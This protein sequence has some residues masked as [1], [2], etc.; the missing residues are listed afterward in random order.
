MHLDR[1]VVQH[2]HLGTGCYIAAKAHGL[3]N[4]AE[5][6]LAVDV[7]G[8]C[9]PT[10]FF[11]RGVQHRQMLG[12]FGHQL[13]AQ[14]QRVLPGSGSNFID[15]RLQINGVLV[16]VDTA[17]E[18]GWNMRIAHGM[19]DQQIGKAVTNRR[20]RAA[21]VQTLEHHRIFAIDDVLR[22]HGGKNRLAGNA[23][24]QRGDIA[25]SVKASGHLAL[26]DGVV[27][28][29]QHVFLTRPDQLDGHARHFLGNGHGLAH[30]VGGAASAKTAPEV[31][32]VHIT[33]GGRQASGFG[34]SGQGGF[35]VLGGGPHF[36][37]LRR[38]ARCRVHGFHRGVVL[39]R[40]GIHRL[41][42]AGT[43]RNRCAGIAVFIADH[44][45]FVVET[46]F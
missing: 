19:V 13:A 36:T 22:R 42:F 16:Q 40:V 46:G 25:F 27:A 20:F 35:T 31:K 28:A 10:A 29:V 43:G 41:N 5:N 24:V 11:C 6:L 15:E 7:G 17:P 45:V 1:A 14:R 9:D 12:M 33:L 3:R 39:K 8:G 32:L 4:P 30:I 21:R 34:A 18:A 38:P 2:R 37:A 26:G 44:S 23:H